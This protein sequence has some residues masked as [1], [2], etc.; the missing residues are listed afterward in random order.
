MKMFSN[1]R[2][3]NFQASRPATAKTG[4]S[5]LVPEQVVTMPYNLVIMLQIGVRRDV[6]NFNGVRNQEE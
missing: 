4:Y 5:C 1:A 3:M 6:P 2:G